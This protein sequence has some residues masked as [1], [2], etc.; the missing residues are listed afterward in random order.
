LSITKLSEAFGSQRWIVFV[1]LISPS[2]L[3]SNDVNSFADLVRLAPDY[4]GLM[5]RDELAEFSNWLVGKGLSLRFVDKNLRRAAIVGTA[6]SLVEAPVVPI[7]DGTFIGIRDNGDYVATGVIAIGGAIVAVGAAGPIVGLGGEAAASAVVI[8]SLFVVGA[9]G[10]FIYKGLFP[11][12]PVPPPP[13]TPSRSRGGTRSA[14]DPDDGQGETPPAD[15]DNANSVEVPNAVA[16][17]DPPD[18]V[19]LD[20]LVTDLGEMSL[21]EIL[22][23]LPIGWDPDTG[24]GLDRVGLGDLGVSDGD[25]GGNGGLPFP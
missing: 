9:A 2:I 12:E 1:D 21:S 7:N 13:R 19:D 3:K 23:T 6:V 15:E 22:E 11:D 24:T 8:G 4:H 10:Y 17:G 16:V 5:S 14:L 20:G 25:P 18:G